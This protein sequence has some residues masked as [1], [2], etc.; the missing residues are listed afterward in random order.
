L[1]SLQ[2]VYTDAR[3]FLEFLCGYEILVGDPLTS[4]FVKTIVTSLNC[5]IPRATSVEVL[6]D[7]EVVKIK[8]D[9]SCGTIGIIPDRNTHRSGNHKVDVTFKIEE[10]VYAFI[11]VTSQQSDSKLVKKCEAFFEKSRIICTKQTT[12]RLLPNF[13]YS[14]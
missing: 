4:V 11:Q 2:D 7:E 12:E 5:S 8:N 1:V 13:C 9:M 10:D 14:L 6:K 3:T